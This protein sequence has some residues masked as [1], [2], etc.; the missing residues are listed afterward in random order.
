MNTFTITVLLVKPCEAPQTVEIPA[1]LADPAIEFSLGNGSDVP[2]E[3]FPMLRLIEPRDPILRIRRVCVCRKT[4]KRCI[5][6]FE[7]IFHD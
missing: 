6:M 3:K 7:N 4:E 5:E 1:A 2:R